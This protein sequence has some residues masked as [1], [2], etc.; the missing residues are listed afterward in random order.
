M[1]SLLET[2]STATIAQLNSFFFYHE[3]SF[4]NPYTCLPQYPRSKVSVALWELPDLPVNRRSDT[5]VFHVKAR[6]DLSR[7]TYF[8]GIKQPQRNPTL[9]R[10]L[11]R[12][13]TNT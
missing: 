13:P 5:C 8:R 9:S 12:S 6:G 7:T 3:T 1:Y 10:P 4:G 11:P 2:C